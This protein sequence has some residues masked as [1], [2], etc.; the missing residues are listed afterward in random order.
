MKRFLF[1][2][3][4]S[5]F[6]V[7]DAVAQPAKQNAPWKRYTIRREE[8]S[9]MLPVHPAMA[10]RKMMVVRFSQERQLRTL[11]AYAD[12]L[13]FTIL[14]AENSSPRESL[15]DYLEQEIFTHAGWE[16][17][18]EK[19][20]TVNSFK[21]K[22]YI[23]PN[24]IPGT[25]QIFATR[26]HIYRFHAFGATIDD[27]R[28]KQFFSSIVLGPQGGA[29]EVKDGNGVP[30]KSNLDNANAFT[31]KE[32]DQRPFI[33]F[34]PEPAYTEEARQNALAGTV[35]LKAIFTADGVVTSIKVA[36]GLPY[37]LEENAVEAAKKIRFIPA[38][39]DGKFVSTWMQLEYSFNLY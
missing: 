7:V 15:D 9:V 12:G 13:A 30:I 25:M 22:Q 11:G 23:V 24:K 26:N 34:K 16:R 33:A 35:L 29:I 18:S 37:G 1:L 10:T 14:S 19:E 17:S 32:V 38:V 39:K 31:V 4:V 6:V 3:F 28:V 5:L 2:S 21:G 27:A 8:F 36:S 20:I